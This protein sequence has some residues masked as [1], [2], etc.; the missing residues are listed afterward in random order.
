MPT[1]TVTLWKVTTNHGLDLSCHFSREAAEDSLIIKEKRWGWLELRITQE[2]LATELAEAR[3]E[4]AN[5]P[6][7]HVALPA[8]LEV[9]VWLAENGTEGGIPYRVGVF[10]TEKE[11]RSACEKFT[12]EGADVRSIRLP[13]R[14]AQTAIREATPVEESRLLVAQTREEL[15]HLRNIL[16]MTE[17]ALQ[18]AVRE[19]DEARSRLKGIAD[20]LGD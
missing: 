10:S 16:E 1:L 14:A 20:Y 2:S 3:D 11:A 17:S 7:V 18:Q 8:E 5:F 4:A 15:A 13:V 9:E 19:R 6:Q 12:S